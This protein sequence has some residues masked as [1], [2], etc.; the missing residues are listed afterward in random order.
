MKRY[1][2]FGGEMHYATGGANDLIGSFDDK[3]EASDF[4]VLRYE[5]PHRHD[6]FIEWFHIY[7]NEEQRICDKSR[8][9]PYGSD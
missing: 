5:L 6:D 2:V 9:N 3:K 4:A 1:L 8:E 7:D